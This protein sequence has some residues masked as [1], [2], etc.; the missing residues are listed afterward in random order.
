VTIGLLD[1]D[2]SL[3]LRGYV[4]DFVPLTAGWLLAFRAFH[5]RFVP[6]W[7]VGATLGVAIR[8]VAL[9]HLRVGVL[10]FWLVTLAF[11]GAVAALMRIAVRRLGA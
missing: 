4:R 2:G 9:W 7:L 3:S 11:L 8:A 10:A 5:G 1:H 6:T